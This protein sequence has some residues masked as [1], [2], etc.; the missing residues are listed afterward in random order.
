MTIRPAELR[1]AREIA[2]LSGVLGYSVETVV[3]ERRLGKLLQS[4]TDKVLVAEST[5]ELLA[6]WIHGFLSR[7]IESEYRVEIGG[8]VV[9]PIARRQ[10][11]G[12]R[13][14]AEIDAWAHGHGASELSVRC[15]DDRADAHQFYEHLGFS[16]TKTQK[17][18]RKR[19]RFQR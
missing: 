8:L 9:D 5:N 15:R 16:C 6:G 13:L 2:R 17:V 19:P 4:K 3:I 10:G 7:L 11:V 18:F 14:V 12:R 1:D